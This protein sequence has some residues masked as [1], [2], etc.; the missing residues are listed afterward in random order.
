[1]TTR[2]R[3]QPAANDDPQLPGAKD[4]RDRVHRLKQ[5]LD[6]NGGRRRQTLER[7]DA[8]KAEERQAL[9]AQ[10]ETL[11][12]AQLLGYLND[13]V[14]NGE[15]V[16]ETRFYWDEEFGLDDDWE[17]DDDEDEEEE[18][19][20]DD[21]DEEEDGDEDDEEFVEVAV[22]STALSWKAAAQVRV[23]VELLRQEDNF[24]LRIGDAENRA[25]P[26]NAQA[27]IFNAFKEA[28]ALEDDDE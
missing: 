26:R 13:A 20:D 4:W 2:R 25:T 10:A 3:R 19:D 22:L 24:V 8:A 21:W 7:A 27:G 5:E 6:A 18:D 28:L 23:E 1:M 11:Q 9:T 17:Y 16:I 15:G 14:L 12:I